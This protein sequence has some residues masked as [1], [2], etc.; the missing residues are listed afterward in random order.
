MSC[1]SQQWV[2][3]TVSGG[4]G[5][6]VVLN[7]L[8]RS[9]LP[10]YPFSSAKHWRG[11]EVLQR[12][13]HKWKWYSIRTA[14]WPP[15]PWGANWQ[16]QRDNRQ[17]KVPMIYGTVVEHHTLI[18]NTIYTLTGSTGVR[19]TRYGEPNPYH[20]PLIIITLRVDQNYQKLYR[21]W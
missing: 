10:S 6:M 2:L 4:T 9:Q 14:T 17:Q 3:S 19:H 15:K 12:S 16:T 1:I 21:F 18:N 5:L 20:N 8:D 7:F 13:S 11:V